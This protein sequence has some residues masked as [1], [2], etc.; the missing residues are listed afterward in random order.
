MRKL[1][2]IIL[3]LAGAWAG[4][5]WVGAGAAERGYKAWFDA[6]RTEGWVAEYTDLRVQGFPNRFDMVADGVA[7]ADP[8]TG[9][10]WEAEQFQILTLSY[11]P[12]HLIAV[13]PGVQRLST[14]DQKID[15][16]SDDFKGSLVV[17][18]D[19]NLP[20]DRSSIVIKNLKMSSSAGWTSSLASANLA[21]RQVDGQPNTHEVHFEAKDLVPASGTIQSLGADSVLPPVFE[22]VTLKATLGFDAPWDRL[23]IERARPQPTEIDLELLSAKWGEMD[24]QMAGKVTVDAAGLPTGDVTVKAKNWRQ[25]VEVAKASGALAPEFESTLVGALGLIAGLSGDPETIDVPLGFSNGYMTLGPL[26]IGRAP[27]IRIR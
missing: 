12:N 1:I 26:P 3:V 17:E 2:V 8:D 9:L 25:M 10:S 11:K 23:A 13:W 14:P 16:T 4:Y 21:T 7:L 27:V 5:W 15:I 22:G 24:L 20:L 19:P 6:R 18:A